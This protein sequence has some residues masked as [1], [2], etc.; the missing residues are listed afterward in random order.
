MRAQKTELN[1]SPGLNGWDGDAPQALGCDLGC[2]LGG[3]LMVVAKDEA[4]IHIFAACN[5][6]G[7]L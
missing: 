6:G 5:W 3:S 7:H 2:D 1:Q 4:T